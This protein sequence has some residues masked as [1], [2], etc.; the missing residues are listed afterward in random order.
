MKEFLLFACVFLFTYL[1]TNAQLKPTKIYYGIYVKNIMLEE[2]A[3]E[4]SNRFTI[5]AYW[6][7]RYEMPE[8]SSVLKEIENIEFV[9]SDIHENE[10]DEKNI[11]FDSLTQKKVVYVTGHMK[12]D[13]VFYPNYKYYP[14]DKLILPVTVESKNLVSEKYQLIPDTSSYE[15]SSEKIM[16]IANDIEIPGFK[17]TKSR[18]KNDEKIYE[19]NFG[20]LR[21]Q[22]HLKYSRLNFEIIL[23][24]ESTTFLLKLLIPVVLITLMAYLVFFVPASKLEVAV[25]LTV[26]SLLS[27][28]A[29]QLTLSGE[30]PVTGYLNSSDKIFYLSYALI[31]FAMI[32]TVYTYNLQKRHKIKLATKLEILS[33]WVYPAIFVLIVSIIILGGALAHP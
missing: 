22:T 13:F 24:R 1:T 33:R 23:E 28:I 4:K 18:Y 17:I 5:N 30:I 31:T 32:Q 26:T 3:K 2:R 12:G 27:C 11:F 21:F 25:G 15:M 8:D 20:D 14:Q 29:L 7:M 6:W 10:I 16:G 9:N 19:T